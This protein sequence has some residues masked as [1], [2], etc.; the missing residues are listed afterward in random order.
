M[1]RHAVLAVLAFAA[2]G[3]NFFTSVH[4]VSGDNRDFMVMKYNPAQAPSILIFVKPHASSPDTISDGWQLAADRTGDARGI[5]AVDGGL[6][7]FYRDIAGFYTVS[8]PD[9]AGG[10]KEA[11]KPEVSH[12]VVEFPE[13]LSTLHAVTMRDGVLHI[14]GT[15]AEGGWSFISAAFR[16]R[17]IDVTARAKLPGRKGEIAAADVAAAPDGTAYVVLAHREGVETALLCYRVSRGRDALEVAR[18]ENVPIRNVAAWDAHVHKGRLMVIG[19]ARKKKDSIVATMLSEDGTWSPPGEIPVKWDRFIF[20]FNAF[21]LFDYED[22][23]VLAA[24]NTQALVFLGFDEKQWNVLGS[25]SLGLE[26]L[27][28]V[29]FLSVLYVAV[30]LVAMGAALAWK[31]LRRAALRRTGTA[32]AP[33]A[34]KIAS[35]VQ[36]LTAYVADMFFILPAVLLIWG[37][38][39]HGETESI[40]DIWSL[41]ARDVVLIPLIE[42]GVALGYFL[43]F[44]LILGRTPGKMLLRLEIVTADGRRPGPLRILLRNLFRIVDGCPDWRLPVI[45]A[46]ALA[47]DRENQRVGDI[48]AGTYVVAKSEAHARIP[49]KEPRPPEIILASGSS[50]RAALLAAAGVDFRQVPLDIVEPPPPDGESAEDYSARMAALKN[51]EAC[52]LHPFAPGSVVITADTVVD[53]GGRIIGKPLDRDDARQT[54]L[55]LTREPHRVVTGVCVSLCYTGRTLAAVESAT[56]ELAM[57]DAEIDAYLDTGEWEGR[58]GA[59]AIEAQDPHVRLI[60]GERSTVEGLP[61]GTVLDM[62]REIKGESK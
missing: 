46:A 12:A 10:Q 1:F 39:S 53:A 27:M 13:E 57:S 51:Q 44:E 16:E 58:S 41:T 52:N 36:R 29:F 56:L 43:V 5:A 9:Q 45:G 55:L 3:C 38:T 8:R 7:I 15:D 18:L 42:Q 2:G 26:G 54:L 28:E 47:M 32:S 48:A 19:R 50:I 22:T 24:T 49:L 60:D 30:A 59:Y 40:T 33:V 14:L 11:A 61:I 6:L 21:R 25:P 4:M 34:R 20:A 35:S 62:L 23:L 37:T 17:R 31:A